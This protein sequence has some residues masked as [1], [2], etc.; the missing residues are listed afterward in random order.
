[1]MCSKVNTLPLVVAGETCTATVKIIMAVFQK[2]GILPQ[3]PF[4]QLM[5]LPWE[6]EIEW[7]DLN[8]VRLVMGVGRIRSG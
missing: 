7:Y 3:Y 5:V 6:R 8:G 1:M 4:P 2:V